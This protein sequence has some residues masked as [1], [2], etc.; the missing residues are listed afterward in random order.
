[1]T[2]KQ[3]GP[4]PGVH[5]IEVSIKRE[6]TVFSVLSK[7]LSS[8]EGTFLGNWQAFDIHTDHSLFTV[9]IG[10]SNENQF[11]EKEKF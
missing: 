4:A 7:Q 8:M 11:K 6:L 5:L 9:Y 3:L 2:E 1:M 10:Y